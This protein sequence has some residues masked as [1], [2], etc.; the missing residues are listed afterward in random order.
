MSLSDVINDI[1]IIICALSLG[2][3]AVVFRIYITKIDMTLHNLNASVEK[4]PTISDKRKCE[5]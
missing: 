5:K 1:A 2:V 3:I 4:I